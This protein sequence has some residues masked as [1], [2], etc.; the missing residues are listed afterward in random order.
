MAAYSPPTPDEILEYSGFNIA[1]EGITL[2]ALK[3]RLQAMRIKAE[4]RAS[5]IV[6]EGVFRGTLTE[7]QAE[8]LREAVSLLT[9][10]RYLRR[11]QVLKLTGTQEPVLFEDSEEFREKIAELKEE[12]AEALALAGTGTAATT[13][14]LPSFG[15]STF[16]AGSTDR[17]PLERLELFD[18]RD[19][20]SYFDLEDG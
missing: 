4:S 14:R 16:T 13:H 18:E 15:A 5:L 1:I 6:G 12:A 11:A 19:D 9:M 2:T 7:D 10:V 8:A 20:I 3:A 17:T